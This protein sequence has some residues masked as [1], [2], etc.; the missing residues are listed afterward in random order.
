MDK[1][2]WLESMYTLHGKVEILYVVDGY[3]I[4]RTYDDSYVG[5]PIKAD[6]LTDC[7]EL[8][9]AESWQPLTSSNINN[10]FDGEN[11]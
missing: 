4:Q 8:A 9:M 5:E 10:Y 1:I 2:E 7:I 6:T 3:Q 11:K